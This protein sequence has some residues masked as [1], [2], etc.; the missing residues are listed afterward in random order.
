MKDSIPMTPTK[1][2]MCEGAGTVNNPGIADGKIYEVSLC[3]CPT[4]KG[5]GTVVN[6]T[7]DP[8]TP[9]QKTLL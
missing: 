8:G 1:C 7:V 4:C 3:R 5:R 6:S 2:P 9:K